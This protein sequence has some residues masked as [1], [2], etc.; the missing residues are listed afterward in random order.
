M[1]DPLT[2]AEKFKED[3]NTALKANDYDKAVEFY[4]KAIDLAS[5]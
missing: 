2:T 5:G 4:T 3:G 1:E